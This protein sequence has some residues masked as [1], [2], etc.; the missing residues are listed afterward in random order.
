[1]W[2]R[3]LPFE[4]QF[5]ELRSR[6][7]G[8]QRGANLEAA[9]ACIDGMAAHG[10]RVDEQVIPYVRAALDAWDEQLPPLWRRHESLG[11][12]PSERA[13][14]RGLKRGSRWLQLV[15]TVR[16]REQMT[17]EV[18]PLLAAREDMSDLR[19]LDL[20]QAHIVGEQ[21][22][23]L[24]R[25]PWAAHI[26]AL[27]LSGRKIH[28]S[29]ERWADRPMERLEWLRLSR[30]KVLTMPSVEGIRRGTPAL[31]ALALGPCR[32]LFTGPLRDEDWS[33][34][35]ALCVENGSIH[36]TTPAPDGWSID[37]VLS[38]ARGARLR[39]LGMS[40]AALSAPDAP[41]EGGQALR[42]LDIAA[43]PGVMAALAAAPLSD[44]R[45]LTLELIEDDVPALA[46]L[47]GALPG[48]GSLTIRGRGTIPGV[49][50]ALREAAPRRLHTLDL[51]LLTI[52]RDLILPALPALLTCQDALPALRR[53]SPP[54][55]ASSAARAHLAGTW[56]GPLMG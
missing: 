19:Q 16:L 17:Q 41:I 9:F 36:Y 2:F 49:A 12:A 6:L 25:A 27:D 56:L 18:L 10:A 55:E 48:L 45:D 29:L 33:Q 35:D 52:R 37:R 39:E 21:I 14:L 43:G 40:A 7:L 13:L 54:S 34:L 15:R 47:L 20:A 4:A 46:A 24:L 50:D 32:E 1:M 28:R 22:E 8:A 44:L 30:A 38:G 3:E 51:S 26:T 53:F 31:R 42:T 5:G 11:V 23:A